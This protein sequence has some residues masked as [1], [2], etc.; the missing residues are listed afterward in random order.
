MVFAIYD[1]ASGGAALWTESHQVD[2]D[3]GYFVVALG[4]TTALPVFDGSKV[5]LGIKVAADPEMTPREELVSVPYAIVAGDV[6][7]DIHPGTVSVGGAMVIDNDGHWVGDPT[8][9]IGPQGP[10]GP[11]G[12]LGP[13]GPAGPAGPQG[14]IGPIGPM[15]PVGPVG[16]VGPW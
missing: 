12:P 4:E 6:V 3:D 13:I 11:A 5:F 16:P 9:L 15:G 7:G 2:L 1:A 14:G 8:G 10:I